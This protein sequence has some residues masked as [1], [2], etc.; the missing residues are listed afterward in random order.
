M[1]ARPLV[2][3]HACMQCIVDAFD[4]AKLIVR[5]IVL[6]HGPVA[7]EPAGK[8]VPASLAAAAIAA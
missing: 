2:N 3:L 6:R 8:N 1:V 4:Y 7:R 5:Q